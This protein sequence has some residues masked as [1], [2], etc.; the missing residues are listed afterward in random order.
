[1][2]QGCDEG[3]F[4]KMTQV[5]LFWLQLLPTFKMN[6]F[7]TNPSDLGSNI[8]EINAYKKKVVLDPAIKLNFALIHQYN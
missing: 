7:C 4:L 5:A 6:Y 2:P 8:P 1:M 3:D